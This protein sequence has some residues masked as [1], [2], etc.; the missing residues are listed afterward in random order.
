VAAISTAELITTP[1]VPEDLP[2]TA[3]V[4]SDRLVVRP[5][6]HG[7]VRGVLTVSAG[8]SRVFVLRLGARD[9][10]PA[11][12]AVVIAG[13]AGYGADRCFSLRSVGSLQRCPMVPGG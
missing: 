13:R 6:S 8:A 9:F 11:G 2:L 1:V 10:V 4:D 7:V 5:Y 3:L 12:A